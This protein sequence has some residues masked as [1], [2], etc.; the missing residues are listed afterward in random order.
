MSNSK[1]VNVKILSPNYTKK[2]NHKI[3]TI[4]IH[5]VAGQLTATQLGNLFKNPDYQASSNYGIGVDCKIGLYVNEC[6]RSWCSSSASNDHRAITIEVASDKT[7]PYHV[8]DDVYEK[9]ILLLIDICQRNNIKKLL[10][11]ADKS[12]IGKIDKQNMTVHRWFKNKDCP[13]EYLYNKH[14]EIAQ[15]VNDALSGNNDIKIGD[16]VKVINPINFDTGNKFKLWYNEYD[17][18]SIKNDRIVIG[19]NGKITAPI[20]RKYLKICY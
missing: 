20:D 17:V 16:T 8:N 1:L 11:K 4:T 2:R 18:I 13:G 19:K 3:D 10:W 12:L 7:H 14:Y 5:C 9:L 15:R 6:D